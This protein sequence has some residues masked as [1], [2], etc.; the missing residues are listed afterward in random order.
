MGYNVCKNTIFFSYFSYNV[1]IYTFIIVFMIL[2][3]FEVD[4]LWY[5]NIAIYEVYHT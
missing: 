1:I 3:S 4:L 5:D 2:F